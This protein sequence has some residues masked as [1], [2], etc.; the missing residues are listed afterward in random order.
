MDKRMRRR[1]MI[2]QKLMGLAILAL[3]ALLLWV[4]STGVTPE[5]RDG[6]AVL[7]LAPMGFYLIFSKDV[8]IES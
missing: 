1:M 3:C 6:T 8:V 5:D 4:C 7:I 2:R